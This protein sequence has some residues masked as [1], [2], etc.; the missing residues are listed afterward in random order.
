MSAISRPFTRFG[1]G[2]RD[3]DNDGFLDIYMANGKVRMPDM[4]GDG[5][6]Y[7]E[8]N[9]LIRGLP[10]GRFEEVLPNGGVDTALSHTSRGAAFGD[11]NGDGTVDIVV[12]NRD[13]PA[14]VLMNQ[15][16]QNGFVIIHLVNQY[17]A[18]AQ[19]AVVQYHLKNQLKRRESRSS[20]G[21]CSAHDSALIIGLGNASGIIDVEVTWANGN[22]QKIRDL[23]SGESVTVHQS[24]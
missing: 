3:F 9:V 2:F 8:R 21:Y 20:G 15:N 18:P 23:R 14:Y 11:L 10:D 13:M 19:D 4:L 12:V 5:D 24:K 17:G 16:D 1:T 6:P 7:A 22:T